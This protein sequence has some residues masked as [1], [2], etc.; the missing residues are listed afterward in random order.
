MQAA[1]ELA[2]HGTIPLP[3]WTASSRFTRPGSAPSLMA[4][5]YVQATA[6]SPLRLMI[7]SKRSAGPPGRFTPRSQSDTRLRDTLR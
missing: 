7:D 5:R 1:V 2:P 3:D 6:W 4:Y